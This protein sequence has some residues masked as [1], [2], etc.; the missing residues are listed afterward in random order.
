[1]TYT[2]RIH[3]DHGDRVRIHIHDT[4]GTLVADRGARVTD[5]HLLVPHLVHEVEHKPRY[6]V[7]AGVGFWYQASVFDTQHVRGQSPTRKTIPC[8]DVA[9]AIEI[10]NEL[11]G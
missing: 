8:V 9:T 4:T 2:A 5:L 1:M 7:G 3:T 11:N 10:A 6:I